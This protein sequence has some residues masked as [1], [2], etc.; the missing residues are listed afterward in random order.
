V[1][2]DGDNVKNN[3]LES[4]CT[5]IRK[6]SPPGRKP[7]G[8]SNFVNPLSRMPFSFSCESSQFKM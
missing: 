1:C 4:K 5:G 3:K 8:F 7:K 6:I 2:V